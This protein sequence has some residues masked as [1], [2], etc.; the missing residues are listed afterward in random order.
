[1]P[2][3]NLIIVGAPKGGT[4]TLHYV[5]DQHPEIF[6]SKIKEPGF[7]WAHGQ[8]VQLRGHSA[9]LLRHRVID[10]LDQYQEL[11]EN[12]TKAK[13][14]GESSASYMFHP[15]SPGLIHQF[16]PNARLIFILRQPAERAFSSFAQY[17]RDGVE[18]CTDFAEAVEQER[19]GLRDHWT[20]G[21]H[22]QYGHYHVALK[23]YLEY[24]DRSQ[25]HI[26][27]FDDLKQDGQGFM[28]DLF[29][30][31]E[32]DDTFAP[33]MSHRHNVSGVI[34]NPVLRLFWT[35][36]NRLRAVIRPLTTQ[37]MRH[38]FSER[39]FRSLDKPHFSPGLRAELTAYYRA[40]IEQLQDFLGRDLSHWLV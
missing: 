35:K 10:N 16:I 31:L 28:R 6:M 15:R 30:F 17:L 12:G 11:F 2:L 21:R 26:S 23:R 9:I 40:D 38:A 33:D 3:P 36:T 34:R 18:P 29:R 13:I 32:V 39:V 4:T 37:K 27:L 5:L 22:L 24:F 20:F 1:M 8:D 19:Q 14:I 25:M 7:F